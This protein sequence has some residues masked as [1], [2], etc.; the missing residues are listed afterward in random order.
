MLS[1]RHFMA[2]IDRKRLDRLFESYRTAPTPMLESSL[3]DRIIGELLNQPEPNPEHH[4]HNHNRR[5]EHPSF[6][7]DHGRFDRGRLE[8]IANHR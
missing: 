7:A 4:V 2:T 1:S 8:A 6:G 5:K 3:D